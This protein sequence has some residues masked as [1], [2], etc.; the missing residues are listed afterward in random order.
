MPGKVQCAARTLSEGCYELPKLPPL[1]NHETATCNVFTCVFPG[2]QFWID[3]KVLPPVPPEQQY[4]FKLFLNGTHIINWSCDQSMDWKG[5][6]MFGLFDREEDK[7]GKKKVEK[8]ALCFTPPDKKS[9]VWK[10]VTDA[11]DPNAHMEIRVHRAHGR[12]RIPRETEEYKKTEH[13]KRERGISLVNAGRAGPEIPRR[14]YKFALVDPVDQPFV[15]FRYYYRTESQLQELDIQWSNNHVLTIDPKTPPRDGRYSK[16]VLPDPEK[17]RDEGKQTEEDS[18]AKD[19][20]VFEAN[21]VS[22]P[23]SVSQDYYVPSGAPGGDTAAPQTVIDDSPEVRHSGLGTPPRF[24]RLSIPP[25]LRFEPPTTAAENVPAP[26]K[27]DSSS[28]TAY[29]PHPAYPSDDWAVRTP[30][31]IK[32]FR[33]GISTPPPGTR[34]GFSGL[35]IM[36]AVSNAWKKRGQ[37]GAEHSSDAGS[38]TTSRSV[39]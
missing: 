28:S 10:D 31:P 30:S 29:R 9:G 35:T 8:R 36:H 6:T 2:S 11:L 32:S 22:D 38:R 3:Y 7:D 14:F 25:R 13:A 39:S 12:K 24:Y 21:N 34:R 27:S 20:D 37:A 19:E 33:D 17:P 5:K 18:D 1:V 15:T 4:L 26:S 23:S 16:I